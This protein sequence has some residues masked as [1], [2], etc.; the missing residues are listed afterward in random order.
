MGELDEAVNIYVDAINRQ[1][2]LETPTQKLQVRKIENSYCKK[3]L[4]DNHSLI[5]K[6]LIFIWNFVFGR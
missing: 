6:I 2:R 5:K 4:Y 1:N 3:I